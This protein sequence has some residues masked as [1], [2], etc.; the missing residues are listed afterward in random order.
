MAN[1][2]SHTPQSVENDVKDDLHPDLDRNNKLSV[3]HLVA[4]C[5]H[6]W[7]IQRGR[8]PRHNDFCLFCRADVSEST[9]M[10]VHAGKNCGNAWPVSCFLDLIRWEWANGARPIRCPMC[11]DTIYSLTMSTP[12]FDKCIRG[13]APAPNT[14]IKISLFSPDFVVKCALEQKRP[15]K[16]IK[17][18]DL[19]L[20]P[21]FPDEETL[22][23]QCSSIARYT[24]SHKGQKDNVIVMTMP[25]QS[26]L[27]TNPWDWTSPVFDS[28]VLIDFGH[29]IFR[30]CTFLPAQMEELGRS[31]T[32]GCAGY[33]QVDNSS[34]YDNSPALAPSGLAVTL[35]G[36]AAGELDREMKEAE[37]AAR[38][39]FCE[40][41]D[42]QEPW[43]QLAN[44]HL[45]KLMVTAGR[46]SNAVIENPRYKAFLNSLA[47]A[48]SKTS[49]S[50]TPAVQQLEDAVAVA[51]AQNQT[52]GEVATT[53]S[54]SAEF[55]PSFEVDQEDD[56]E[57]EED[58]E[59]MEL[60]HSILFGSK[61][62][63]PNEWKSIAPVEKGKEKDKAPSLG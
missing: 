59:D 35:D 33:Q 29:K 54:G 55:G 24:G 63:I 16:F 2:P 50:P 9:E 1:E 5:L 25:P 14:L 58:E 13:L 8:G 22:F 6:G 34:F 47:Q 12:A 11:R 39:Y 48:K 42:I 44:F 37:E 28:W 45:L 61:P 26:A 62:T 18:T 3:L 30:A 56:D 27:T 38:E 20:T 21:M 36:I 10:L 19:S 43:Q 23:N 53:A 31:L 52:A 46:A 40:S 49:A 4:L 60:L 7:R 32:A 15:V 41:K 57:D 51:T 17:H